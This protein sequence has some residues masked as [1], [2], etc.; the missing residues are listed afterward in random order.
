M[1]VSSVNIQCCLHPLNVVVMLSATH[2]RTYISRVA[3]FLDITLMD[4]RL[5]EF[6]EELALLP[7]MAFEELVAQILE[8]RSAY[9]DIQR[10]VT[11]GPFEID[12]VA[13]LKASNGGP[14]PRT[15]F[16]VK[17]RSVVSADIIEAE[18]LKR[19]ELLKREPTVDF[20]LI[21][22]GQLT[23]RARSA[24]IHHSLRVWDARDLYRQL[25]LAPGVAQQWLG[26]RNSRPTTQGRD[27]K[28]KSITNALSRI[29]SGRSDAADYQQWVHDAMEFLFVPPIGP[30][31]FESRDSANRNRR[32]I[33]LENWATDGFWSLLRNEYAARQI[34]IDAKN[35][36]EPI[37]KAEVTG[38]AHYLK[39]KGCGLLGILVSRCGSSDAAAH[40]AKE[41]WIAS[42]KLILSLDDPE[43]LEMV[44][45]R[46]GGASP[47]EILR[48][49]IAE[50]HR[51]L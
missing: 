41:E 18:A 6:V 9:L 35:Y 36:S 2:A 11:E 4:Y 37:G 26:A 7:P 16:D 33:I 10:S 50:F 51:S 5:E 15:L 14:G 31:H 20:V 27:R 3:Q 43:L 23:S 49:R 42:D 40:A 46:A 1:K 25:T 32:D 24:A 45:L 17:S 22:S 38:I 28:A 39:R 12:I 44:R 48:R 34:V 8:E 21:T 29:V 30:L 19:A 13:T 47:D